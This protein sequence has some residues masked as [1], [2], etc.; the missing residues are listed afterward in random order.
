MS[1]PPPETETYD[2]ALSRNEAWVVHHVL[3]DRI[4]AA[5]DDDETPPQWT[6]DLVAEIE[7]S[8]DTETITGRQARRLSDALTEYVDRAGTPQEDIEH[9]MAVRKRLEDVLEPAP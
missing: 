3:S 7:S 6:L 4:T 8:A 9:A 2:V 5:I 1:S